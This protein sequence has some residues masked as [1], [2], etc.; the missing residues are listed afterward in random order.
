M[1]C[2]KINVVLEFISMNNEI[3]RRLHFYPSVVYRILILTALCIICCRTSVR[4]TLFASVFFFSFTP[5]APY[6]FSIVHTDMRVHINNKN[7]VQ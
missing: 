6:T 2:I 5:F 1:Q 4:W 3:A 7:Q